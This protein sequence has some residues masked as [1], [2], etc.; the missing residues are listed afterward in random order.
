VNEA[1]N[2]AE[3]F[4]TV[5]ILLTD[6]QIAEGIY[7]QRPYEQSPVIRR[8]KLIVDPA[9][10]RQLRSMDRYDPSA[11]DGVSKRWLPGSEAATYAAQGDEHNGDGSV[12][13]TSKN[14]VEQ[15]EKRMRKM[16]ALKSMLP[17]PELYID[18]EVTEENGKLDLLIVGWG[19]TKA[20]VLDALNGEFEGKKIGYL[21]YEYLW[22]IKTERLAT[23]AGKAKKLVFIEGNYTGQL[24]QLVRQ[25]R[26]HMKAEHLRKYNGRPFFLNEMRSY[27]ATQLS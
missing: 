24:Y 3:E 14:A 11:K 6:K 21:H 13:E 17:E 26:G 8:G 23:L 25:D 2:I 15:M 19:S 5:V 4:Q 1:F 22:P 7:T 16:E 27:L 18:G 10:L 20:T 12:D 9:E